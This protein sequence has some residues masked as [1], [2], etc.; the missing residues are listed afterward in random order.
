MIISENP[1][2]PLVC[3]EDIVLEE[4]RFSPIDSAD[5]HQTTRENKRKLSLLCERGEIFLYSNRL[6]ILTNSDGEPDLMDFEQ[7]ESEVPVGI[8]DIDDIEDPS[9]CSTYVNEIFQHMKIAE[10]IPHDR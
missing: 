9:Y 8:E 6:V 7:T 3:Q 5:G 4:G 1:F 2:V 10:V